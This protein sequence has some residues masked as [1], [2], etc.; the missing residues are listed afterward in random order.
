M[1]TRDGKQAMMMASEVKVGFVLPRVGS[2][3]SPTYTVMG[4]GKAKHPEDGHE[5]VRLLVQYTDDAGMEERLFEPEQMVPIVD[6]AAPGE[7]M[8]R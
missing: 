2:T 5:M 7:G 4:V 1:N 3:E 6:P 8:V